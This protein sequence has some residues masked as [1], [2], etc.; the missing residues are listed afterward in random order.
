MAS[1][2][3]LS[4]TLAGIGAIAGLAGGIGMAV[5]KPAWPLLT[6]WLWYALFLGL[7]I[8]A[9]P[10]LHGLR[11]RARWLVVLNA[12]V[13]FAGLL[14]T[15]V[16]ARRAISAIHLRYDGVLVENATA[17]TIGSGADSL[18]IQLPAASATQQPW[19]IQLT[20]TSSGWRI[21]P[22]AG[23]EEIRVGAHRTGVLGAFFGRARDDDVVLGSVALQ[24][25]G[26]VAIVADSAGRAIDTLTLHA[27][28]EPPAIRSRVARYD[29]ASPSSQL[30]GR[31]ELGMRGG[32]R[33]ASLSGPR[34]S[35]SAY[36]HFIRVRR[37][38]QSLGEVSPLPRYLVTA[39]APFTVRGTAAA[40]R[41]VSFRDSAAVEVRQ[42]EMRWTF[43]LRNWRRAPSA[44]PGLA[45]F[46]TRNPRPPDSPL[47]A[48]VNCPPN[49]ACGALSLRRLPAPIAHV[50]LDEVGF[51]ATRFGLLGMLASDADGVVLSL[52]RQS[53]RIPKGSQRP[54]AVPV[55]RLDS[56]QRD[57]SAAPGQPRSWVLLS[58][59]GALG[60]ESVKLWLIGGG[61]SLLLIAVSVG[62]A[63]TRITPRID[64]P[65]DEHVIGVGITAILGL[66]VARLII[67]ARVAFFPPFLSRGIETAVGMWVAV[68]LVTLA[69]LSWAEWMPALLVRA[70]HALNGRASLALA[71]RAPRHAG[72]P[73]RNL[74]FMLIAVGIGCLAYASPAAVIKGL[75][76]GALVLLAW[77]TVAWITAFASPM[78]ETFERGAWSVVEQLAPQRGVRRW[79]DA[80]P[81]SW[82]IA[83]CL[84]AELALRWPRSLAL[85]SLLVIAA[86]L[87]SR[88][89]R[90]TPDPVAAAAGAAL[91]TLGVAL[92]AAV[93]ENGSMA[94]F[95]LVVFVALASVRIGRAVQGRLADAQPGSAI[96]LFAARV[97]CP[98]PAAGAARADR[99]GS[100]SRRRVANRLCHA[101][102]CRQPRGASSHA[103]SGGGVR[104]A[105]RA[106]DRQGA[107][108]VGERDPARRLASRQGR[109]V[110][111]HEPA[112]S[113]ESA[114]K[115][116]AIDE[117]RRRPRARHARPRSRR[118][119]ARVGA[120]GAR[121]RPA[122]PLDRTDL[123][124]KGVFGRRPHR[125]GT[126]ASR[127]RRARCGRGGVVRGERLLG[128]RPRR[129]WRAGRR[130]DSRA[131]HPAGVRRAVRVALERR[132]PG[133]SP[134]QPRAVHRRHTA[135]RHPGR[136][137]GVEQSR[138]C[139]D[140]RAEHALSRTELVE[141]RRALLGR[142]GH[143]HHR[144]GAPRRRRGMNARRLLANPLASAL[145][146]FAVAA[147]GFTVYATL[148]VS[149]ASRPAGDLNYAGAVG[150]LSRTLK[151]RGPEQVGIIRHATFQYDG[152]TL[153]AD[154][155]AIVADTTAEP[156]F[157]SGGFLFDQ[158]RSFNH[159]AIQN[160]FAA[161]RL[162][163]GKVRNS[164]DGASLF[165]AVLTDSG[166]LRLSD[167]ANAY[168]LVIRSPYAEGTWRSVRTMDW[169]DSPSLVGYQ[170]QVSLDAATDTGAVHEALNGRECDVVRQ[171]Q[172]GR[173]LVYCLSEAAANVGRF[174]DI[175]FTTKRS[176]TGSV[177]AT[178][179]PYRSRDMWVN[180]R[181]ER[182][183]SRNANAG[184]VVDLRSTGAFLLSSAEWGTLSS[185]QWVNGRPT[186]A[187]QPGQSGT[188]SYF[189]RAGRSTLPSAAR[190][191][192]VLSLDA[193]L[194]ADLDHE[195][196]AF[197]S[198]K[199]DTLQRMAVAIL[200]VATGEVRAIAEPHRTYADAPLV[201]LEPLLI[202]SAVKPILMAALLSRQ[203]ALAQLRIES[204][205][206]RVESVA[207]VPLRKPFNSAMNGCA[208]SMDIQRFLGCSNNQFAAELLV[209]SLERNGYQGST[210]RGSTDVP[211][212]VIERS[213]IV[214]GMADLFDVDAF[215]RRTTA[216]LST[217][218]QVRDSAT[219]DTSVT[220]RDQSLMPWD[221]RPWL[222]FPNRSST[223][224]D[225]V[226]RYAFG[227]WENRWT[228]LGAAQAYDRIITGRNVSATFLHASTPVPAPAAGANA[229]RAFATVRRGLAQV[230][231][232]GTAHGIT[233]AM[234][235]GPRPLEVFAKTGTLNEDEAVGKTRMK[236]LVIGIGEGVTAARRRAAALWT[237]CRV[238][239]RVLS[240]LARRRRARAIA[241]GAHGVRRAS[242]GGY[243]SAK[244]A[245]A[246]GMRR[247]MKA[248]TSF[249]L[250]FL[251]AAAVITPLARADHQWPAVLAGIVVLLAHWLSSRGDPRDAELAD[252]SY[253][254]GFLLTL[255]LLAAG[256][257][258]LG[259]QRAQPL[260]VPLYGFLSDLAAGL[261]LTIAGLADPADSHALPAVR[262]RRPERERTG[263][264]GRRNRARARA[265]ARRRDR[266]G[267][268]AN[269]GVAAAPR[270][271]HRRRLGHVDAHVEC[272]QRNDRRQRRPDLVERHGRRRRRRRRAHQD[273][274]VA[275]CVAARGGGH[276]GRSGR[277]RPGPARR[278][279]RHAR[280]CPRRCARL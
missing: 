20:N 40:A 2:R 59:S 54:T 267:R 101:A 226:A 209:R 186:F 278:R 214:A 72:S 200:D 44:N 34:S 19:A 78:F 39:A 118:R 167:T 50:S 239:L 26:D 164:G 174:F 142:G 154:T 133:V 230:G 240:S 42:G 211:R 204:P 56:T 105:R 83:A 14:S 77:V 228:L 36:E 173:D 280:E 30:E 184:M 74:S 119:D 110:R 87:I 82:L 80:I 67:G 62:V 125:P 185:D 65:R 194:S 6:Y 217:Y 122:H 213:D 68:A 130:D 171:R 246:V 187:N 232:D 274:R 197:F 157:A 178:M 247:A 176:A 37:R 183:S 155:L 219:S 276:S 160:A 128:V 179:F 25:D 172:A 225:L 195:A 84:C 159:F 95:V 53:I 138:L 196:H 115:L 106:P 263:A 43:T 86:A 81:E 206:E 135:A 175:G 129:T 4:Q 275:R 55:V 205:S 24:H 61:L 227:G 12:V 71:I 121:P 208:G 182:V 161:E 262:A 79:W 45:L 163:R 69:L 134:R 90:R 270:G 253:F 108:S 149:L 229:L 96:A 202:G 99:H 153:S 216:R 147:L 141:R 11:E 222:L 136:L 29:L 258:S 254:L 41:Q 203:P 93:S 272:A 238:L 257:W 242:P 22:L 92:N 52:P 23:V 189:G 235:V 236:A 188:I 48:G 103:R 31:Y 114:G 234:Q 139:A 104:A 207:G 180:G 198:A 49:A 210:G 18:D 143:S 107:L 245:A 144:P 158:A 91:F 17:L 109:R 220:L 241:T 15:Q 256:L 126:G 7:W 201:S 33:L 13:V 98:A 218:W 261:V 192:L 170:G 16:A 233:T 151:D 259:A 273:R 66:L 255:V 252:S 231:I 145:L 193:R 76:T 266:R 131:L 5:W 21:Q 271:A 32:F 89:G 58:A 137:R 168:A 8:S 102:C 46:F 140:H 113:R 132:N 111:S 248:S 199:G 249:L 279:A 152:Q 237:R 85:V 260:D 63:K 148:N 156:G 162:G 70:R 100:L 244:L 177:F 123:G 268:A 191:P 190:A 120:A 221:S 38:D 150:E 165:R 94:A 212:A 3:P 57:A 265:A 60:D 124:R 35:S 251:V 215:A 10:T 73:H 27:G 223:P 1:P 146:L 64:S 116:W 181:L 250:S 112:P 224:I 75:V 28:D 269:R 264:A 166:T 97:D 88:R 127:D 47:P 117:P 9:T 243:S 51:D 169:K 277:A